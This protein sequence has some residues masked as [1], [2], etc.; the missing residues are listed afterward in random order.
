VKIEIEYKDEPFKILL[1]ERVDGY[2]I[3]N[4]VLHV[5]HQSVYRED[6][7]NWPLVNIRRYR[8]IKEGWGES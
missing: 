3:D 6:L 5:W 4:G 2:E 8:V 7:G 1:V